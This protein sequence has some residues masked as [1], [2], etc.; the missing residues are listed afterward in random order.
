MGA[1]HREAFS[2]VRL[3][4]ICPRSS[5]IPPPVPAQCHSPI[6]LQTQDASP[7]AYPPPPGIS[8]PQEAFPPTTNQV[9]NAYFPSGTNRN[10]ARNFM[11]P[12][13]LKA[14]LVITLTSII[15]PGGPGASK[16]VFSR[17]VGPALAAR[18]NQVKTRKNQLEPTRTN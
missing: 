2:Q 11:H 3:F 17:S 5:D 13:G 4:R 14:R 9:K 6:S 12:L 15:D 18:K 1:H 7:R 16:A 8:R 10:A